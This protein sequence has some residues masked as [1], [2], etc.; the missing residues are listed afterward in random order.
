MTK[1]EALQQI[2]DAVHQNRVNRLGARDFAG[3]ARADA[4]LGEAV[5]YIVQTLQMEEGRFEQ[6]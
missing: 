5:R 1:L 2:E 4:V 3:L 6:A